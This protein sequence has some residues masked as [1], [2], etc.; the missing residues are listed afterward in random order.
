MSCSKGNENVIFDEMKSDR[1]LADSFSEKELKEFAKIV[2]F[3]ENQVC[4]DSKN[5]EQ[6]YVNYNNRVIAD[7]VKNNSI[8]KLGI[9]Y[10]EQQGL[11]KKIDPNLFKEIWHKLK[12]Q[13]ALDIRVTKFFRL[14]PEGKYEKFLK[15]A[16]QSN[17]FIKKYAD[18]FYTSKVVSFSL[19]LYNL[20][21]IKVTD[22]K[23]VKL[24]LLISIHYLT[25]QEQ[26]QFY[27]SLK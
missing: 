13:N 25:L 12:A 9:D 18:V 27:L 15:R 24:K 21:Q 26:Q 2:G 3:F 17:K 7:Y 19:Y 20:S 10:T 1:T 16:G 4:A 6:C 8:L 11:Y 23:D 14:K 5:R 22:Y